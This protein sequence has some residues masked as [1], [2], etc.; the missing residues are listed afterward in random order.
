MSERFFLIYI[1]CFSII[2]S[3]SPPIVLKLNKLTTYYRANVVAIVNCNTQV[4]CRLHLK[5]I[6]N[7]EQRKKIHTLNMFQLLKDLY[8]KKTSDLSFIPKWTRETPTYFWKSVG[9]GYS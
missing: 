7:L 3:D 5:I 8:K 6:Y 1:S 4:Q 2:L 9:D